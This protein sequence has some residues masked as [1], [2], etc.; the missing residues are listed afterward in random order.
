M[1]NIG[2]LYAEGRS[3]GWIINAY[4]SNGLW[5]AFSRPITFG[6]TKGSFSFPG[7]WGSSEEEA[8]LAAIGEIDVFNQAAFLAQWQALAEALRENIDV[9]SL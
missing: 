5:R 4:T 9:R 6:P 8:V 3:K 7:G 2:A 1:T